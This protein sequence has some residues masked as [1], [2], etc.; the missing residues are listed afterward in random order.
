VRGEDDVVVVLGGAAE[1]GE[2][3]ALRTR[4]TASEAERRPST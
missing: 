1:L 3:A 4:A 2:K